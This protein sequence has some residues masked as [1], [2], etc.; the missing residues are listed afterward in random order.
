[1]KSFT[2]FFSIL[3]LSIQHTLVLAQEQSESHKMKI[4]M[5]VDA[6]CAK[7]QFDKDDNACL[8]AIEINTEIFYVEGTSIDDH[9]DAHGDT[10]FCNAIR[11]AHVVGKISDNRFLLEKFR[12]LKYR[13]KK[14]LY[15][16]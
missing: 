9:G 16:D 15:S 7:C 12:L 13:P 6:S 8:L 11:K 5:I 2:L 1:M 10:G 14:K 3:F 4:N